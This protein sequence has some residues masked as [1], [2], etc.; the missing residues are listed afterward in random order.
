MRQN[1]RDLSHAGAYVLALGILFG[2][3]V[4]AG[5]TALTDSTSLSLVNWVKNL[6]HSA[7]QE[8]TRLS[9]ASENA[10][11]IRA[12]LAKPIPKLEPLA[13]ITAK[14]AYG[15]LKPGGSGST[16]ITVHASKRKDGMDAVAINLSSSTFR[17]SSTV[18]PELHKIY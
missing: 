9:L 8:Q 10:R 16:A 12:A 13:P 6:E 18:A 11:E 15:H 14:L 1:T 7:P 5:A 2:S 4:F 17:G 3:M